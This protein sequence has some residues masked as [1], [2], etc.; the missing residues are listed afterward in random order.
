[1]RAL[2]F[3]IGG[4]DGSY[5]AELLIKK[6]YDVYGTNRRSSVDNLIR[7]KDAQVFSIL[8]ADLT[9]AQ[10]V[11]RAIEVSKPDEVYNLADQDLVSSSFESPRYSVDVTAGGVVN[12][13]EA[14]RSLCPE[15]KVFQP[16]SSTIFGGGHNHFCSEETPLNP[17]SPYACAKAHAL[18]LAKM[19]RKKY[20]MHVSTAILY[21]HN[22]NR[23]KCDY[24]LHRFARHAVMMSKDH[25]VEPLTITD[26]G[27]QVD[28]GYA[29]E[30]V[31][32]MYR[33]MQ[34]AKPDDVILSTGKPLRVGDLASQALYDAGVESSAMK[35]EVQNEV[36]NKSI[37]SAIPSRAYDLF[38]W[39]AA[40]TASDVV[41][42]LVEHYR[43]VLK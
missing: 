5:M 27:F 18:L 32:G 23:Q 24:L 7:I 2:I 13:L 8:Q 22:S 20:K 42:K 26:P 35:L 29:P 1:M 40:S 6:G 34:L 9:D 39:K 19:Y 25:S 16:C 10:S 36:N 31:E 37:M 17:E 30:F 15:A 14:V 43:E 11:Y 28:I 3:G 4:Q 38:A 41:E 12:I 33:L 21:G